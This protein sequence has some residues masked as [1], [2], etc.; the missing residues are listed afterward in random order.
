MEDPGLAVHRTIVAVD[1]QRFGDRQ[2]TNRNQV[3]IRDGLYR[4][5]RDAFVRAG[6][7]VG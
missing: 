5:M 4:A 6:I 7:P 2:R 3:A 1:V